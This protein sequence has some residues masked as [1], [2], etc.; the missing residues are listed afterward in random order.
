MAKEFA[1]KYLDQVEIYIIKLSL[2]YYIEE[3][4]RDI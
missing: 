1:G 4:L 2:I 3:R